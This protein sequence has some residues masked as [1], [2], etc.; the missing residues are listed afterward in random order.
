MLIR[1]PKMCKGHNTSSLLR[2][3]LAANKANAAGPNPMI[4]VSSFRQH[5]PARKMEWVMACIA[6]SWGFY[7]LVNPQMFTQGPSS[8]ILAGLT[9]MNPTSLQ[10]HVF[11][12]SLAFLVGVSRL[13]ALTVNGLY[14][15]TPVIR[16][17]GAC[18]TAFVF[19][20]ITIALGQ[21]GVANV[22]LAVYPWLVVADMV[23]AYASAKDAIEADAENKVRLKLTYGRVA[24]ASR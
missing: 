6:T 2:D 9:E 22:G 4:L 14:V 7:A 8:V 11:W 1:T 10:P 21:S 17:I 13:I 23:S 19:S 24:T 3:P 5:W 18:L 15:R 16:L 12:G 20:Q